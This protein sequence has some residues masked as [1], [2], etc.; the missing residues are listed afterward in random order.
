MGFE[1][2]EF[3]GPKNEDATLNSS[4]TIYLITSKYIRDSLTP[5][6]PQNVK[7]THYNKIWS[8]SCTSTFAHYKEEREHLYMSITRMSLSH[9]EGEISSRFFSL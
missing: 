6:V 1:Y 7:I 4:K 8:H 9:D 5:L 2:N 3:C